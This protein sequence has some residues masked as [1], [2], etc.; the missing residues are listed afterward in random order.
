[1]TETPKP[2]E[3][4]ITDDVPPMSIKLSVEVTWGAA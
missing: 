1:M 3:V 4:V 2:R